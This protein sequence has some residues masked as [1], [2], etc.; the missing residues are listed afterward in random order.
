M[1]KTLQLNERKSAHTMELVDMEAYVVRHCRRVCSEKNIE[2]C[3]SV[4]EL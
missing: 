1:P 3:S 4:K 2:K